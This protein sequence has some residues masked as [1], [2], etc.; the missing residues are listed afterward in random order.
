MVLPRVKLRRIESQVK[1]CV[2]GRFHDIQAYRT[3]PFA[4]HVAD[5]A[6]FRKC[7]DPGL[8]LDMVMTELAAEW[9][10][11]PGDRA[12]F[13]KAMRDLDAWWEEGNPAV[14]KAADSLLRELAA[15]PRLLPV[16]RRSARPGCCLGR[17]GEFRCGHRDEINRADFYLPGSLWNASTGRCSIG[18]FSRHTRSTSTG[19]NGR[20]K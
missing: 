10:V 5:Y 20:K 3:M 9:R 2:A 19:P 8:D 13:V 12:K 1:Q 18:A 15:A 4:Q 16:P 6:L 17:V 7:W 11:P 14:L